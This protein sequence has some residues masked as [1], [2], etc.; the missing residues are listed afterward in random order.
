MQFFNFEP[1]QKIKTLTNLLKRSETKHLFNYDKY[2]SRD[3][4]IFRIDKSQIQNLN[5][6]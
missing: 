4:N 2:V 1:L 3:K 6:F 5:C